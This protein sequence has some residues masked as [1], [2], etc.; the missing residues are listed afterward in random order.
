MINVAITG[1][2][3]GNNP[4]PG[5][6]V[7]AGLRRRFPDLRIVGL[8]YDPLESGLYC[9]DG[10]RPD[11]AYLMPF[12]GAGAKATLDRLDEILQTEPIDYL[13]PC[14]DSEL[15]NYIQLQ[16]ELKS[17]GIGCLLPS[18]QALDDRAKSNL[19]AFCGQ[20]EVPTPRTLMANDPDTLAALALQLGYPVYVKGRFYEAH[21]ATTPKELYEAFASIASVWGTPVLVQEMVVGEEYDILG[22]GDGEGGLLA[23]CSIRKM[24]RTSAGKGFAGVVVADPDLDELVA[25]VI[26]ALR[27]A[28]PFELEFIKVP[29]KPH[30]LFE[31]NPRFPAWVDFPSQIGCN[32]P[33]RL[34]EQLIGLDATPLQTCTPGQMFIRHSIDLVADIAEVAEMT[35]TGR[36]ICTPNDCPTISR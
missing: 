21:L 23:S 13:I 36:R 20:L 18:Q 7:A 2:H 29:G 16:P 19:D 6:A 3:R 14:L 34:L 1:L 4:Q 27:W 25:R 5:A 33:A 17:R 24:L 31:M 32:M 15:D 11:V 10:G 9:H 30:A 12:P 28:G 22:L 26:G 35:I 8:S